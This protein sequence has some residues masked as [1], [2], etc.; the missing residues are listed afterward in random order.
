M[1]GGYVPP[2]TFILCRVGMALILFMA[3]HAIF[4]RE[5]IRKEDKPAMIWLALFGVAANQ[6]LFF[7]GLALTTPIHAALIMTIT[8]IAVVIVEAML[9]EAPFTVYKVLGILLA[10]FGAVFII[11][12]GKELS[13]DPKTVLGDVLVF[14]NAVSYSIYLVKIKPFVRKYHPVTINRI[15]FLYGFFMV[16]PFGFTGLLNV[17]WHTF[18]TTIW[19]SFFYVLIFTTFFA[20]YLNSW[21]MLVVNPSVVGVYIYLQPLLTVLIALVA[22]TDKPDL[23]I[24]IAGLLI[25]GGVYLTSV[26]KKTQKNLV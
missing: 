22:G 24:A 5:E 11:A 21:A 4:I 18:D 3:Y 15:T 6:L 20:Y 1:E 2:S 17:E 25:F 9:K 10:F 14:A 16:L 12:S 26:G 8:P 13:F 23:N 19:L 7:L